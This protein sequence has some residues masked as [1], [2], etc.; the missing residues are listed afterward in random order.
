MSPMTNGLSGAPAYDFQGFLLIVPLPN[1]RLMV[2]S[3][4]VKGSALSRL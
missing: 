2:R 4:A 3:K 1:P